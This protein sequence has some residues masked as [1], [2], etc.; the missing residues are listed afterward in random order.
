VP[1]VRL[2]TKILYNRTGHLRIVFWIPKATNTQSE[3]VILIAFPLQELWHA[4]VSLLSYMYIAYLVL[5]IVIYSVQD[6]ISRLPNT[7]YKKE[8]SNLPYNYL[9][10]SAGQ[11]SELYTYLE[12]LPSPDKA[13]SILF[14]S[15]IHF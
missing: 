14:T 6:H 2:W 13:I 9:S 11:V 1:F 15:L 10:V 5:N 4:R 7:T 3:Y 8:F 12:L